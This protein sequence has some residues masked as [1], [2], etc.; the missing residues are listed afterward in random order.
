MINIFQNCNIIV[1]LLWNKIQHLTSMENRT[2]EP[3]WVCFVQNHLSYM[4]T[5]F[6]TDW[7]IYSTRY[8][9]LFFPPLSVFRV[10]LLIFAKRWEKVVKEPLYGRNT[11]I[12]WI[13]AQ[14]FLYQLLAKRSEVRPSVCTSFFYE[15][16]KTILT[17]LIINCN[18][19][20]I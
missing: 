3:Q 1:L 7:S 18:L 4:Q 9:Q 15:L 14:W 13:M 8:F 17:I 11:E 2:N 10:F 16:I 12:V 5:C 6:C 20:V 19:T